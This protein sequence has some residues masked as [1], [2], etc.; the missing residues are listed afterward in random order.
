MSKQYEV[1]TLASSAVLVSLNVSVWSARKKDKQTEA[2]VQVQK[3]AN[4]KRAMSVHK[5]LFSD[6]PPLDQVQ[7]FAAETRQWFNRV[8]SPWDDNGQRLLPTLS[9]F[10]VQQDLQHKV[11]EFDRLVRVFVSHYN[12]E[13]SRQAF[14]LGSAFNRTE[15]PDAAQVVN[16]FA[17][18]VNVTPLPLSGDFRVNIGTETIKQMQEAYDAD[19]Q[20][21]INGAMGDAF[22]RVR[23]VVTKI[24]E[25]MTSLLD[26]TPGTE[27]QKQF[28]DAG[29]VVSVTLIKKRAPKVYD[30]MLEQALDLCE[31]LRGLNIMKDP[32]LEEVR[33]DLYNAVKHLDTDT[34]KK[35]PEVQATV[36]TKMEDILSKLDF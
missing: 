34:L 16:K 15:Y 31:L 24:M 2:D 7:A 17:M 18:R 29:N 3:G 9:W 5:H 10:E 6:C 1:A 30:S 14:A 8:T 23:D 21:R 26:Y 27:E 36:K 19:V 28:D 4:N 12:T 22:G 33:N 25:R 11:N 32:V 20:A 13:I 35:S